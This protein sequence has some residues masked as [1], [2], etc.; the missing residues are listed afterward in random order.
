MRSILW[1][2]KGNGGWIDSGRAQRWQAS[3]FMMSSTGKGGKQQ[4]T[5]PAPLKG[6]TQ[7]K[8]NT[9]GIM[10]YICLQ[11]ENWEHCEVCLHSQQD[12]GCLTCSGN[13]WNTLKCLNSKRKMKM[14][15]MSMKKMFIKQFV[16]HSIKQRN[17]MINH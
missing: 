1:S 7:R 11:I 15:C 3:N 5:N 12:M 6:I 16:K 14:N 13:V 17:S 4:P 2:T 10:C 8:K 9:E